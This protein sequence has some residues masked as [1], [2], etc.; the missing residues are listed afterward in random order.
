MVS[1]EN[2]LRFGLAANK[3]HRTTNG[4]GIETWLNLALPDIRSLNIN[5][6]AVGG[7]YDCIEATSYSALMHFDRAPDGYRGGLMRM[8]SRIVG[9]LAKGDELDGVIYLID[10]VDPSSTFP[11]TQALKRQCVIHG[12]PFVSTIFGAVEWVFI[13]ACHSNLVQLDRIRQY[14]KTL[15]S[16]T[17]ALVA[18]DALKPEMFDFPEKKF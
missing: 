9:G 16:Q 5:F 6:Y 4:S 3:F 17:V 10:P 7:A 15:S 8:V 18:H 14:I 13:E 1:K 11:E 2:A 12:K